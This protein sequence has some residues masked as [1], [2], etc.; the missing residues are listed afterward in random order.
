[1]GSASAARGFVLPSHQENFG[2]VVAEALACGKPVLLADQVNIAPEIVRDGGGWMAPDTLDGTLQLLKKWISLFP[3]D[4][5]AMRIQ[6][7][8]IFATRFD[9][10]RNTSAI[11]ELFHPSNPAT[12]PVSTL[13][14]A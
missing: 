1:M 9:M 14:R 4:E 11:V 5:R 13:E 12:A 7:K 8:H 10:R 6:A 2:F 3:D